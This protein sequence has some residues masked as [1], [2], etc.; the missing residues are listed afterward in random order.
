M[1]NACIKMGSINSL[2]GNFSAASK[3]VFGV[4]IPHQRKGCSSWKKNT[5]EVAIKVVQDC[6]VRWHN[7]FGGRTC[8]TP[9]GVSL[10]AASL[11]S[12][13][14]IISSVGGM[15]N[16]CLFRRGHELLGNR[17]ADY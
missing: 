9:V 16:Y 12:W 13:N 1:R 14:D 17:L 6:T 10:P 7:G 11:A 15:S 5:C 4:I 8:K 3:K 2:T